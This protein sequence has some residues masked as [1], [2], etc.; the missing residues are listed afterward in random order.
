[1][2]STYLF[3][4]ITDSPTTQKMNQAKE[5]N[6]SE[7]SQKTPKKWNSYSVMWLIESKE[8][9]FLIHR[10]NSNV[11]ISQ[12]IRKKKK[13]SYICLIQCIGNL[14]KRGQTDQLEIITFF[15]TVKRRISSS[16]RWRLWDS[17][18]EEEHC[19]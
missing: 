18:Y 12:W 7:M 9:W 16:S 3:Q 19:W 11:F 13:P 14:I 8:K 10:P 1:M 15:P 6:H 5:T 2:C 4:P 17:S